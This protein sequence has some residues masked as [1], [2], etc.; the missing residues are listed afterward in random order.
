MW[1]TIKQLGSLQ[2]S[3]YLDKGMRL[4]SE[5]IP[6][7]PTVEFLELL[8]DFG[9]VKKHDDDFYGSD[10]SIPGTPFFDGG[11]GFITKDIID[12]RTYFEEGKVLDDI[13]IDLQRPI[14]IP[15][16][17]S[18]YNVDPSAEIYE[19][20][21][22]TTDSNPD[23]NSDLV[24]VAMLDDLNPNDWFLAGFSPRRVNS[25]AGNDEFEGISFPEQVIMAQTRI[26]SHD[27]S[28]NYSGSTYVSH[29][30][31]ETLYPTV[32]YETMGIQDSVIRGYPDMVYSPQLTIYRIITTGYYVRSATIKDEAVAAMDS[33]TR[34]YFPPVQ[35]SI[36]GNMRS[37]TETERIMEAT[38]ILLTQPNRPSVD[39]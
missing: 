34:L 6:N 27:P 23:T 26:Y 7:P 29:S 30:D 16:V 36:S 8:A 22:I 1:N 25:G 17:I 14:E 20:I 9:G 38:N 31:D 32:Y 11:A 39:R 37:G 28:R 4:A 21:L 2:V 3:Y 33:V 24:T 12:L 13:V 19:T 18:M 10:N 35:V 15:R 5:N